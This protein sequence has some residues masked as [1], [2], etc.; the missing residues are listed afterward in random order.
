MKTLSNTDAELKKSV[1]F[2]KSVYI[3][4]YVSWLSTCNEE[5][6]FRNSKK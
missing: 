1:A 3:K 4:K 6:V 2:K 5:N